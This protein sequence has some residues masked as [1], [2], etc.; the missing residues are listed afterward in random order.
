VNSVG[1]LFR[2]LSSGV[3]KYIFAWLIPSLV[4][5]AVFVVLVLPDVRAA[6]DPA[7]A[8]ADVAAQVEGAQVASSV[9]PDGSSEET[10]F[11]EVLIGTAAF[12]I[13]VL[14]L[15]TL[16]GLLSTPIYRVL[17]G[18]YLPKDLARRLVRN[19]RRRRGRLER[20]VAQRS[21]SE[22]RRSRAAEELDLYPS[23]P[24]LTMPTRLGNALKSAETYAD[25]HYGM[26]SQLLWFE[27]AAL[28]P[29]TLRQDVDDSRAP[30]DFFVSFLANF[31]LLALLSLAAWVAVGS[32][33]GLAVGLV[34]LLLVPAAYHGAVRNMDAYRS[35]IQAL[36]NVSRLNVVR[37]FGL[38]WPSDATEEIEIWERLTEFASASAG[39]DHKALSNLDDYRGLP[40]WPTAAA[41]RVYSGDA[42]SP[43][44]TDVR[45]IDGRGNSSSSNA[46]SSSVER[47]KNRRARSAR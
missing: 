41:S 30:I 19:Q 4:T 10:S 12:G 14:T 7:P 1:E 40:E 22:A 35:A 26:D 42:N 36:V 46:S 38:R 16:F 9:T 37:A 29:D 13:A 18:Y 45:I 44:S 6:L 2:A 5:T 28:A 43:G 25:S 17:E 34:S 23:D 8:H 39:D 47:G 20:T 24:A 32:D 15:A 31:V 21:A 33:A 3:L 11:G 27:L